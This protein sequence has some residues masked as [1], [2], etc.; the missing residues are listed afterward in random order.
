MIQV[1]YIAVYDMGNVSCVRRLGGGVV[2]QDAL[3]M[4]KWTPLL[5]ELHLRKES[6]CAWIQT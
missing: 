4:Q 2:K 1:K 5:S 3:L 6:R